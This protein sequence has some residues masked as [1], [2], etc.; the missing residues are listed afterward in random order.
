MKKKKRLRLKTNITKVSLM[1]LKQTHEFTP[2]VY[3]INKNNIEWGI[4]RVQ[5]SINEIVTIN[6]EHVG[7]KVVNIKK[8]SL[9]TVELK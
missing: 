9:N 3:I 6:F 2:G 8:V 1:N 4:G 7:K 5:S